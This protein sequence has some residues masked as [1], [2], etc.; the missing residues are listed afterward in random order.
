MGINKLYKNFIQNLSNKKVFLVMVFS[1]L[2]L[3]VFIAYVTLLYAENHDLINNK[4]QL[5]AIFFVSFLLVI[6]MSFI[7]N[8][9]VRFILFCIFSSL[10]G[11]IL[12]YKMDKNNKE[13][14]EI[15]KKAFLTTISIFIFMV[16]YAFFLIFLGIHIPPIVG[17]VLFIILILLIIFIFIVSITGKYPLYRKFIS[18]A[19]ILLF[20]LF[21]GYDTIIIMDK[22]YSGNFVGASLD[23]FIDMLNIFSS[24]KNIM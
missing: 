2:I 21:I 24:A 5:I 17:I 8:T 1:N 19:I 10:I 7:K 22:D 12:S 14:V 15:S 4:Y 18:G 16:C 11:L 3:Q 23:Y 13:E 6:F 20:S 9:F